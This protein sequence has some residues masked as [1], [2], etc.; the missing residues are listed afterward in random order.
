MFANVKSVCGSTCAQVYYGMTSHVINVYGMKKESNFVD[1]HQDFLR[2][3]GIPSILCRDN[4]RTQQNEAVTELHQ[5]YLIKDKFSEPYYQ[6]Q[7]PVESQGI[8]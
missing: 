8:R 1:I 4:S 3:E 5:K 2:N 7:N 6:Y